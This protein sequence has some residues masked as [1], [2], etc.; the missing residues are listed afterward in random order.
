[1]KNIDFMG[2]RQLFGTV[3]VIAVVASILIITFLG[4]QKN[5]DFEGGTRLT[6]AFRGELGIAEVR[7]A[8][9]K[10]IPGTSI[11]NEEVPFGSRF[12]LKIK[13]PEVAKGEESKASL[14][15]LKSLEMVFASFGDEDKVLMGALKEMGKEKLAAKLIEENIYSLVDTDEVINTTYNTLADNLMASLDGSD[16]VAALAEKADPE[17]ADLLA[18][19]LPVNILPAVD[20]TTDDALGALLQRYDPLGRGADGNYEDVVARVAEIRGANHDFVPD[21]N[22]LTFDTVVGAEDAGKLNAFFGE[23]FLLSGYRIVSNET[24]SPSIAAELLQN[25]QSA[26][27]LALFGILIY[28]G[29]RFD[30]NYAVASVVALTHDVIICLGVFAIAGAELSSPVVAA[31][32]TIV[33]YSLNDT[34][35][36]FDRI[37]DNRA[38]IKNVDLVK[39][40]N[41]SV[42]QTL[43]RTIV[44]SLTTF[45]VVAV[46]YFGAGNATLHDFA[47]PLLIGI[48]VGTYSS[49]FVAS[50]TLLLLSEKRVLSKASHMLA[51]PFAGKS[52][53]KA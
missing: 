33:G 18:L 39:V 17:K 29:I 30:P 32:L 6:V 3:S 37:R 12:S 36:V 27:L 20:H 42:N 9:D 48:V 23:N 53:S 11:V 35:V 13:N 46:I 22:A 43:S 51:S 7:N 15:R 5:V 24:F 31:F 21:M 40:M 16:S 50:P 26:I 47:F 14:A 2:K 41:T 45:F 8:V 44:T 34:I 38:D 4:I 1:M 28:I 49:I 52:E 25:A 10:V 19:S